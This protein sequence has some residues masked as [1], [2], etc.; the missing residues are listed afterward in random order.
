MRSPSPPLANQ[1]QS[2]EIT[3][4]R[5]DEA[6]GGRDAPR[7]SLLPLATRTADQSFLGGNI[8][9]NGVSGDAVT[10][11]V[12]LIDQNGAGIDDFADD[13]DMA[14]RH[15]AG[16]AEGQHGAGSRGLAAFIDACGFLPPGGGIAFDLMPETARAKGDAPDPPCF[17]GIQAIEASCTA[18]LT[19]SRGISTGP[20]ARDCNSDNDGLRRFLGFGQGGHEGAGQGQ[21]DGPNGL[22]V[23]QARPPVI[24]RSF[25]SRGIRPVESGWTLGRCPSVRGGFFHSGVRIGN[26]GRRGRGEPAGR[27]DLL[28]GGQFAHAGPGGRRQIAHPTV[29]RAGGTRGLLQGNTKATGAWNLG[30]DPPYS[31]LRKQE[32][33]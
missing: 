13:G 24:N 14:F 18:A 2:P 20:S 21:R 25:Q 10:H 16:R 22:K 23:I 33:L 8:D 19:S 11:P 31:V 27:G 6:V 32:C 17:F 15:L 4:D 1:G 30:S 29:A 5:V 7:T 26:P 12:G 9:D 28:Q 3:P